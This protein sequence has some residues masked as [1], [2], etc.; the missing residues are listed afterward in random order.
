LT[1]RVI[2]EAFKSFLNQTDTE[3]YDKILNDPANQDLKILKK[4]RV[5]EKE[6]D[7][8]KDVDKKKEKEKEKEKA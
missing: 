1:N 3:A 8:D 5:V 7:V 6:N 2:I 4:Y